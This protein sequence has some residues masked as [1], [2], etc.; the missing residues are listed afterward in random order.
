MDAISCSQRKEDVIEVFTEVYRVLKHGKSHSLSPPPFFIESYIHL[1]FL[2]LI[3]VYL[4]GYFVVITSLSH[5]VVKIYFGNDPLNKK[6]NGDD[7]NNNNNDNNYDNDND[8]DNNDNDNQK[9]NHST[10]PHRDLALKDVSWVLHE[11]TLPLRN[12]NTNSSNSTSTPNSNTSD[13]R[14]YWLIKQ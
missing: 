6:D 9:H 5:S 14:V 11:H 13:L 8:N 3:S 2:S 10:S 7:Q 1:F 12:N 4:G